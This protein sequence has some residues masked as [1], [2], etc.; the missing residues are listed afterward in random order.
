MRRLPLALGAAIALAFHPL[1]LR[2][3]EQE[4]EGAGDPWLLWKWVNFAILFAGLGYLIS[5][6]AGAFFRTRTGVIQKGIADATKLKRDAEAR[7]AE[8]ARKFTGLEREV[9]QLRSSARAEF[10]LEGQRIERETAQTLKR[11]QFQAGQEISA[12]AKSAQMELQAHTAKLA[13]DLAI[14]HVREGMTVEN[15][16]VLIDGFLRDLGEREA[17]AGLRQ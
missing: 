7:A 17:G 13:L 3:A 11:I 5:K 15:D 10:A 12:T 9:E 2:A 16:R 1:A 14:K 8:I 6:S 4:A